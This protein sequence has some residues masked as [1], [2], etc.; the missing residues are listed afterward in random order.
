MLQLRAQ[1]LTES[2]DEFE[3]DV[4][5]MLWPLQSPDLYPTE[6]QWEILEWM[7]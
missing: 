6:H 1:W 4:N 2:F 7:L 5:H 3:N